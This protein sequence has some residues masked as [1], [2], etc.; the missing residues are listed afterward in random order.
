MSTPTPQTELQSKLQILHETLETK[1]VRDP[2]Q[3]RQ[4]MDAVSELIESVEAGEIALSEDSDLIG[5]INQRIA[6][7]DQEVDQGLNEV[8]HHDAFCKLEASWRGLHYLVSRAETG[9]MLKLR[10]L[11]A[12]KDEI[13]RD[14]ERAV[15]FDQSVQFKK[16]Y[17]E[18]YGTFGGSPYSML[19]GDYEFGRSPQDIKWL[20][21]MS[22]VAAAAHAPF[23]AA[24]SPQMFDM[25]SFDELGNP[26]DLAKI[27]ESSELVPW[28]SFRDSED[29]RYV[30]LCMPHFLLRSPYGRDTRP[31]DKG[32]D[33][34]QRITG[35]I[36]SD[37]VDFQ[38]E[39][40]GNPKDY[41][42]GNAAY[43]LAERIT[44]AFAL[45]RWTAAIRGVEGGGLVEGL[46]A[47]NFRTDEGDV[48][49]KC[50]TEVAITD[51]REKELND[52]GFITLVHRKNTDHAAF[53]GGQ[54]TQKPKVY[55][56]PQAT[57]NARLSSQLPY[58]MAA[59]RFAH[60]IKA[61]MRDKVGSFMTKENV[62]DYLNKWIADYVL[63]DDRA[64]QSS[65]ASFPLREARV[66]VEDVVGK[67]GVYKAVV[68]LRP[69]FQLD[70]LTA[71]I[72]LV[73]E[74]PPPVAA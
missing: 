24:A 26:R 22:N 66:D 10:L 13:Q 70:E 9:T 11:N 47:V 19:V 73:A 63:L 45:Y 25:D 1:L 40:D 65:K 15:E 55:Q 58:V 61:M 48:I 69:H 57:A 5:A 2:S 67:P 33:Q 32:E 16:I 72:R 31:D 71:S 14:L 17:E 27:F 6:A 37:D 7:L 74:L 53:F 60:Y 12:T 20:E 43:A 3:A 28:R 35:R 51:R 36:P 41:C 30:A 29:S 59:S 50:P 8:M 64:S 46:P 18:E 54:T 39:V 68:Y 49:L 56:D 34:K 42:W 21:K 44:N 38:E 23:I 62:S 4:A 52:L